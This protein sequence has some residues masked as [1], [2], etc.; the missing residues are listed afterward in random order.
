MTD[1]ETSTRE[2]WR[3]EDP[4]TSFEVQH[5]FTPN[6]FESQFNSNLGNAFGIEPSITLTAW[7]RPHSRSKDVHGLFL[8]GAEIHPGKRVQGVILSTSATMHSIREDY[9]L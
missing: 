1:R 9:E 7:F 4:L 3:P 8:I 6:D 2:K 5:D